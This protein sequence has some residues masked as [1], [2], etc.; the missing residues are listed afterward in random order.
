ME[1]NIETASLL[2]FY[3]SRDMCNI[4]ENIESVAQAVRNSTWTC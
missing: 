3:I 4:N 2:R 1:I